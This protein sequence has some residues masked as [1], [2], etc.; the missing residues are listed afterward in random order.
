MKFAS[1]MNVYQYDAATN[2]VLS[3]NYTTSV[4]TSFFG[5]TE[6]D[7]RLVSMQQDQ[8]ETR[9]LRNNA[10]WN[11]ETNTYLEF[12]RTFM[13]ND[14]VIVTA[15]GIIGRRLMDGVVVKVDSGIEMNE[16][17]TTKQ[18]EQE[19]T[20]FKQLQGSWYI[21]AIRYIIK[22]GQG[23]FTQNLHLSRTNNM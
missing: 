14:S 12:L 23:I 5:G 10:D 4:F 7:N 20:R 3:K 1:A 15:G 2:T 21:T 13:L 11:Y 6:R 9:I 16:E 8:L 22:V 18:A 19:T 17:K